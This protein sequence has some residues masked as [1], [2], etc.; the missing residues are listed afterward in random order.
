MQALAT[1]L[2]RS[3]QTLNH[4]KKRIPAEACPDIERLTGVRCE[5]LRPDVAWGVL[6]G[7]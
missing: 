7:E 2:G 3:R 6:R 4:W 5:E 1:K